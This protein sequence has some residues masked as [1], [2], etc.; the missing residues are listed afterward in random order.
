[1]GSGTPVR[2]FGRPTGPVREDMLSRG[3]LW[4]KEEAWVLLGKFSCLVTL[5]WIFVLQR[6]LRFCFWVVRSSW[7]FKNL[8]TGHQIYAV[9]REYVI[10]VY[11]FPRDNTVLMRGRSTQPTILGHFAC[12]LK[13]KARYTRTRACVT[14][15]KSFPAAQ[16]AP[17][18]LLSLPALRSA[19]G[20]PP[21]VLPQ[22]PLSFRLPNPTC[23]R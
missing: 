4:D 16:K 14:P 22:A 20:F 1:M 3:H 2:G 9:T 10:Y 21:S 12:V 19:A 7:P 15:A 18:T 17:G 5:F 23:P 11:G 13:T 8:K 6:V